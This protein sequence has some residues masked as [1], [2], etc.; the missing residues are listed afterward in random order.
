M[1]MAERH[2]GRRIGRYDLQKLVGEGGMGSVYRAIDTKVGRTVAV[3]VVT[4][5]TDEKAAEKLRLRFMREVIAVSKV[6]HPNVVDVSD[7][8]FGDD[9]A[10]Y[11]VME[12]LRGRDLGA[13]LRSTKGP[14]AVGYVADIMLEVCAAVRAC[15]R[16][17]IVHRD[18]KPGNIFLADVDAGPGWQVKVLDFGVAKDPFGEN[19]TAHGQIVGTL[20]YLSP[21]QVNGSFGPESDQYSIGVVLYAC[22]TK[23]FPYGNLKNVALLKA[24][25]KGEFPRPREHRPDLPR[26]LEDIILRAMRPSPAERFESVYALGQQLWAFASPLSRRNWERFYAASPSPAPPPEEATT[27]LRVSVSADDRAGVEVADHDDGTTEIAR[28]D[29]T[30]VPGQDLVALA[31]S[32]PTRV[33]VGMSE[34][35]IRVTGQGPMSTEHPTEPSRLVIRESAGRTQ[36]NVLG[37]TAAR[38]GKQGPKHAAAPSAREPDSAE[39]S[40]RPGR[41]GPR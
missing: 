34:T 2:P 6:G 28:Y 16:I 4:L 1:S 22:L 18:L 7:Y 31:A 39:S 29:G 37:G 14:L 36:D 11:L 32:I 23:R 13:V 17:S 30:T 8:G 15:H 27:E 5:P 20:R 35:D 12:L 9:G 21:E 26:A 41:R 33:S 38:A 19:L 10:P 40:P 25:N 3:K 24:I